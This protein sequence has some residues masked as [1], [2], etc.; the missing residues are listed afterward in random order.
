MSGMPPEPVAQT[1]VDDAPSA[2]PLKPNQVAPMGTPQSR[3]SLDTEACKRVVEKMKNINK[4]GGYIHDRDLQGA[5]SMLARAMEAHGDDHGEIIEQLKRDAA[6]DHYVYRMDK[7][8]AVGMLRQAMEAVQRLEAMAIERGVTPEVMEREMAREEA[9]ARAKAKA[10]AK[11]AAAKAVCCCCAPEDGA[12]VWCCVPT[13]YEY[14]LPGCLHMCLCPQQRCDPQCEGKQAGDA[15]CHA[16]ITVFPLWPAGLFGFG[17]LQSPDHWA[18]Q[19]RPFLCW[20]PPSGNRT[21]TL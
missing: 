15:H 4:I 16:N 18:S 13:K 3:I 9:E 7:E 14:I 17:T 11:A 8:S 19:G 20:Y 21:P 1:A 10:E 12:Y 6:T 5:G 2:G